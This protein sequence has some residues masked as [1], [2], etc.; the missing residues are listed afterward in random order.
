MNG[1][2]ITIAPA[3]PFSE[4]AIHLMEELSKTLKDITGSGGRNS[5]DPNDVCKE[6]AMFVIARDESGRAIGCGAFRPMDETTA[7]V[8]R[9]YAKEK[10][11][12]AGNQ[13]LSYLESKA[14]EMGYQVLRLETRKVNETAVSFYLKNGYQIIS[15]YGQYE[16]RTES[17]C[18]EKK[19]SI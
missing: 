15:N 12:G 2:H 1:K 9:M 10:G 13:I 16:T 3:S 8:K 7:E 5:F 4:E 18:F 6:R 17:V 14:R 19:L 11:V